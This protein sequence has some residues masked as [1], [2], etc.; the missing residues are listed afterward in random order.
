M[1]AE[2]SDDIELI[3]EL[4][5]RKFDKVFQERP[6][7]TRLMDKILTDWRG[8]NSYNFKVKSS[9]I[10]SPPGSGKTIMGFKLAKTLIEQ[11]NEIA[12]YNPEDFGVGWV[13]GRRNLLKQA[14]EE[15]EALINCP[16]VYYISQ[17]TNN[18]NDCELRKYKHKLLVI[19][20]AHHEACNTVHNIINQLNPEY[21][22]GLSATPRRMDNAKLCFQKSYQDA[23][24]YTLIDEGWLSQFDHW[25]I[26]DWNPETVANFYINEKEK[27]GKSIIYFP[28]REECNIAMSCLLKAGI[29]VD[30]IT[31]ETDREDQIEKFE[32]D[33]IDVLVNMFVLTEG[34]DFPRLR[35]VFARDSGELPS[36]QMC[37]RVLR[38]HPD[39]PVANIV[40][41]INTRWPFTRTA[42]IAHRQHVW[43]NGGW[44]FIG[45]S[46]LVEKAITSMIKQLVNAK[47]DEKILKKIKTMR[48]K[49][50]III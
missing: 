43:H 41:S 3:Q 13:A 21:T 9:L 29:K 39:I 47:V 17:F 25:M 30:L 36:I 7:Q 35:T 32:N 11:I 49:K 5:K 40:Q 45:K 23:G 10:E 46:D 26:P 1:I 50:K 2:I 12:G 33:D 15:N 42:N 4:S 27:W 31:G 16:N 6:Y 34:F 24:F 48:R 8:D 14:K 19:D 28:N 18:L 44:K 22:L 38:P 20:E 37:G